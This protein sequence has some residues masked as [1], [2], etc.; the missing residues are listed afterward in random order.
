MVIIIASVIFPGNIHGEFH[1]K[2]IKLY[3]NIEYIK[4][5]NL[6]QKE[7]KLNKN[8]YN[9]NVLIDIFINLYDKSNIDCYKKIKINYVIYIIILLLI[10]S[11]IVI[12]NKVKFITNTLHD[13]VSRVI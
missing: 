7:I 1:E 11:F 6:L 4:N 13:K 3:F 8:I 10:N 5:F 12:I 2:I 9:I